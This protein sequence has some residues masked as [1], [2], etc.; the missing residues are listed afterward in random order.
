M[1]ACTCTSTIYNTNAHMHAYDYHDKY[2]IVPNPPHGRA[3]RLHMTSRCLCLLT[4]Q[5]AQVLIYLGLHAWNNVPARS[6]MC[7]YEYDLH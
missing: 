4:I 7:V 3:D 2:L 6:T 5:W 1:H